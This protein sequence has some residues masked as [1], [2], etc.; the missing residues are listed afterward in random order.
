MMQSFF[1]SLLSRLCLL[2]LGICLATPDAHG[3]ATTPHDRTRAP[4]GAR[5]P[6]GIIAERLGKD[7]VTAADVARNAAENNRQLHPDEV[8]FLGDK[9]R[10]KRYVAYMEEQ[11]V[12]LT[13][14]EAQ[15]QLDQYGAAMVDKNW[16]EIHGSD[17][18]T[19]TFI[20]QEVA[21]ADVYYRDSDGNLHRMFAATDEEFRNEIVNLR[22]LFDTYGSNGRI[23]EYLANNHS[24]FM[25]AD[26]PKATRLDFLSQYRLGQEQG[27]S[28]A[29]GT[30][31]WEDA[32]TI[33]AS[34]L[35]LPGYVWN[36]LGSNETGPLDD[37]RM[38]AYYQALL[39]IQHRGYEA[40]YISEFDWTTQQRLMWEGVGLGAV[41][42]PM[43]ALGG[44]LYSRVG[45]KLVPVVE[46]E[47]VGKD[48][49]YSA[50][51]TRAELESL[52]DS[53]NVASTTVPPL[54]GRNV[55]LAGQRHPVSGIVFDTRG[56]PIFDD[57]A[58]FDT[59]LT[60]GQFRAVNYE[61]Q[62]QM[63]SRDLS[64]AIQRGEISAS[65]FTPDQLSQ[66][67]SGAA[68]IDGYTWH[69]HQDYGRMQLVPRDI[70]RATG[71]IGGE[72]MSGGR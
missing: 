69:H 70:H 62:M 47:L 2:F 3:R 21:K 52:Y 50:Q 18:A 71:H 56:F 6:A 9:D 61:Q 59:K 28:A 60:S 33:G 42:E 63:A 12:T 41:A 55:H 68:Q 19:E 32:K 64:Q 30:G 67:Q 49:P 54:D 51:A 4:S 43:V 7:P 65:R 20:R 11:G 40:G 10:V 44:K 13:E 58:V 17:P 45:G 35:G 16:T 53:R 31:L 5:L 25:V 34:L 48:I 1:F 15:R 38:S 26:D 72:G 39:E 57:V 46:T 8:Y 36:T 24:T 14:T 27:H 23:G 22:P 37:K 29:S 66:I